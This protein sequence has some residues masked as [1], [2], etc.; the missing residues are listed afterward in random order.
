MRLSQSTYLLMFLSFE[1]LTSKD[2]LTYSGGTDG[3]GELC[4]SD[5]T[6]MINF[7]IGFETVILIA[8]L[9]WTYF[10]LLTLVF[11]LQWLSLHVVASVSIDF[12]IHNGMPRFIA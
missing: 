1:T 12:L 7:P 4:S 5:L 11:V 3:P 9:F 8:L 2:W 10:F 6:Q